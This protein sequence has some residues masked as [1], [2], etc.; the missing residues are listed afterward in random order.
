MC[1]MSIL[2]HCLLNKQSLQIDRFLQLRAQASNE[3][4]KLARLLTNEGTCTMRGVDIFT[5]ESDD[6]ILYCNHSDKTS[7]PEHLHVMFFLFLGILENEI[8]QF[9]RVFTLDTFDT[10]ISR[11]S[12]N[13]PFLRG[14]LR[15]LWSD[16]YR[17]ILGPLLVQ[18]SLQEV[19]Y[20]NISSFYYYVIFKNYAFKEFQK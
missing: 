3:L 4:S 20:Q 1:L 17:T 6:E 7:L 10:K 18:L 2:K 13:A 5:L 12:K 9:L 8:Q 16:N 14:S 19:K 15:R 11:N